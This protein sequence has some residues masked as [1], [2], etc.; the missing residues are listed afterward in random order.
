M[1]VEQLSRKLWPARTSDGEARAVAGRRRHQRTGLKHFKRLA[2]DLAPCVIVVVEYFRRHGLDNVAKEHSQL[3]WDVRAYQTVDYGNVIY[4]TVLHGFALE[5]SVVHHALTRAALQT[6]PTLHVGY[7]DTEDS[8]S[9]Q[10]DV[11]EILIAVMRPTTSRTSA[12]ST[13]RSGGSSSTPSS[14]SSAVP[15]STCVACF[16][17]AG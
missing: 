4:K 9:N 7:E 2:E 15:S 6:M 11:I 16:T 10:G 1:V 3:G 17:A 13:P 12:R 5:Q 14:C 8:L